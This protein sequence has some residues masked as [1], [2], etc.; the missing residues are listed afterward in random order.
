MPYDPEKNAYKMPAPADMHEAGL[1]II[2]A[3][4]A[5]TVLLDKLAQAHGYEEGPWLEEIEETII[6]NAKGSVTEGV[7]ISS[8][9][10]GMGL[11]IEVV[12]ALLRRLR[13]RITSG[14]GPEF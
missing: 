4:G 9:A 2:A 6:R 1:I 11:G 3:Q 14:A 5:V 13:R 7:P 10:R 8:E 12:S